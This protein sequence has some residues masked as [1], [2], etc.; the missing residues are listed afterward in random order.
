MELH[1]SLQLERIVSHYMVHACLYL[2]IIPSK[3]DNLYFFFLEGNNSLRVDR[4]RLF[5][6]TFLHG[7]DQIRMLQQITFYPPIYTKVDI[8]GK[9]L[10]QVE[11]A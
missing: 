3:L 5:P 7:K 9:V 11:H 2:K 1:A 8:L 6:S 10:Q 4:G